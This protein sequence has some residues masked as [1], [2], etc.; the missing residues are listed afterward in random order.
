MNQK[1]GIPTNGSKSKVRMIVITG[2]GGF[3]GGALV[4][5]FHDRG[6]A[7][8]RAVDKKPLPEWHQHAPGVESFCLDV[9]RE[10]NCVRAC[11]G[12]AEVYNL[13][14]DMGG[15][16]FIERY[17]IECLR[18]VLINTHMIEAA[19]RAGAERYFF[20]SSACAYNVELQKDPASRAL[21]ESDAYPAMAERGYGWEK[22]ISE[23]FCQEYWAERSFRT[24]IARFHNVYG[25]YGTWNG[26]REKAPAAI[27]RK[28][29]EAKYEG[30]NAIQ[31]WGD[32]SQTRSFM[33]I[34]DCV[35]GIDM[36]M[37]CDQLTATPINLGSHELIS[38]N[39]LVSMVED[40]A[41]A[42]LERQYDPC[43]PRGV[44]GRNSDNTLI[45]SVL[46]WEPSTP[47]REGM[48]K[49]YR[50]IEEQYRAQKAAVRTEPPSGPTALPRVEAPEAP[51]LVTTDAS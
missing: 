21:K 47:L 32:G 3:I 45:K 27:S 35:K 26:G 20:S 48:R 30:P 19:Y 6:I 50:W 1:S 7:R 28:V 15:M 31:I 33:F 43:A 2:A 39:D 46:G 12:A 24:Y 34:D 16:G 29:I 13:A 51:S 44:G 10:E 11:E 5:Y 42:K 25:P 14:A 8:I 17:R 18:S 22:L 38:V 4:R 49:T 41:Q 9:S 40:I 23:M 36:I 37:H